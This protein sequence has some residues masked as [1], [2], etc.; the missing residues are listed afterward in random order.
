M[1]D[2]TDDGKGKFRVLVSPDPEDFGWPNVSYLRQGVRTRG[3]VLLNT[4]TVGQEVWRQINGFPPIVG[5]M[6]DGQKKE[7]K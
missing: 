3:W 7:S 1:V 4:V 2:P 5:A 6:A